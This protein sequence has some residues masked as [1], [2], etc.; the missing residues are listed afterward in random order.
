MTVQ[1]DWPLSLNGTINTWLHDPDGTSPVDVVETGDRPQVHV[2]LNISGA[3]A[4]L[5]NGQFTFK[6]AYEGIGGAS[7]AEGES[8]SVVAN[9]PGGQPNITINRH[10]DLP[11]NL[12]PGAYKLVTLVSYD[13]SGW[14]KIAAFH[15]GPVIMVADM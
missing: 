1:I 8:A 12:P 9:L 13:Q 10:V 11:N 14:K 3:A 4:P 6:V 2:Q 15:E 5:L 7:V